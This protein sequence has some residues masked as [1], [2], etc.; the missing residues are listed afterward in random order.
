MK[1]NIVCELGKTNLIHWERQ[2][3]KTQ[4][5]GQKRHLILALLR[6]HI[7]AKF[8]NNKKKTSIVFATLYRHFSLAKI[9]KV[10]YIIKK[11]TRMS[12]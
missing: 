5:V 11:Q 2:R 8:Q 12:E 9:C 4:L 3:K 6:L 10:K 7:K 1:T